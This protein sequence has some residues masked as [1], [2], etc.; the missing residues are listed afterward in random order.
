M[1]VP[2]RDWPWFCCPARQR[3]MAVPTRDRHAALLYY[4]RFWGELQE[5]LENFLQSFLKIF[6]IFLK[7]LLTF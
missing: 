6:Q 3:S 5:T 2:T 1:A 7:K 4:L